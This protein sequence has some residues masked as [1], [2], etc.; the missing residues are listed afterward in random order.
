MISPVDRYIARYPSVPAL[1]YGAVVVSLLLIVFL[2]LADI[3][4]RYR[5]LNASAEIL[6]RLG[7]HAQA[8]T[9]QGG[10]T[11]DDGPAG[12]PFL[13]GQTVTLASAALLQRTTAAIAR[14]GGNVVSSEVEPQAT[15]PKDGYVRVIATCEIEQ[16]SLQA[17]LYDLEAGKPFLFLDQV[18]VQAPVPATE[19][20][21]MRVLLGVSGLWRAEK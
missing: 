14:A 3:A 9:A 10:R 15:Q 19:G 11:T 20:G 21:R 18:V 6:A 4:E 17:L 16:R 2:A 13:E 12:S 1:V 8:S 5:T 7:E